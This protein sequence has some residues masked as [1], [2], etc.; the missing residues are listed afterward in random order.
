[1]NANNT[2]ETKQ[3]SSKFGTAAFIV[4]LIT[5]LTATRTMMY[6][7]YPPDSPSD[8]TVSAVSLAVSLISPFVSLIL[9]FIGL[10]EKDRSQ[11]LGYVAMGVSLTVLST[12]GFAYGLSALF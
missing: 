9:A 1:M 6:L 4:S 3:K 2:L 8:M 10:R 11:T 5:I 7:N 12:V